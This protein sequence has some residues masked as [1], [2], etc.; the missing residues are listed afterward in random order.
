LEAQWLTDGTPDKWPLL[1]LTPEQQLV[2]FRCSVSAFVADLFSG[3]VDQFGGSWNQQWF[4]E[5]SHRLS[6]KVSPAISAEDFPL[7]HQAAPAG[8]LTKV[9]QRS[10]T[11][12]DFLGHPSRPQSA[13]LMFG[14]PPQTFRGDLSPDVLC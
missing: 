8:G 3:K 10:R 1:L 11:S 14:E 2:T 12:R 6:F 7:L 4:R 13:A 9:P 5:N